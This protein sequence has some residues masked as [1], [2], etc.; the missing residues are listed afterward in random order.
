VG[1]LEKTS[2]LKE[3]SDRL[4]KMERAAEV[5]RTVLNTLDK[6]ID[7]CYSTESFWRDNKK[8]SVQSSFMLYH[9]SR[10]ARII[11]QR[12]KQRFIEAEEKHQNPLVI[13]ESIAII[14][15][16]S[17]LCVTISSL[18]KQTLTKDLVNMVSEKVQYLREVAFANSLLPTP[19]EEMQELDE[20]RLK[21]RFGEFADTLQAMFV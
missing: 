15:P 8:E 18:V 19:E 3:L 16:L 6:L 9:A 12:M 14:P 4:Q 20:K 10:N 21:K 17:E 2:L 13:E 1:R 11:L 5:D 7:A